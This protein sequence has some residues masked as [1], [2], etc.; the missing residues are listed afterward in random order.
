MKKSLLLLIFTL[1]F[2]SIISYSQCPFTSGVGWGGGA[3][4]ACT[5][6]DSNG[7]IG[8]TWGNCASGNQITCQTTCAGTF[9]FNGSFPQDTPQELCSA[10]LPIT[11][12]NF[13]GIFTEPINEITWTT[14]TEINN[15]YFIIYQSENGKEWNEITRLPGAGHSTE[16]KNYTIYHY[17][18]EKTINYYKLTQVDY[19]GKSETYGPISIDNRD[20]K[21]TLVKTINLMGQ[22]V[23]DSY[24]GIVIYIY[25][26]G[27]T[28]KIHR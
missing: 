2:F 25:D 26:D 24:R 10:V 19:D 11:L 13:K 28:E 1:P 15:N 17:N 20:E 3:Q 12:I 8:C 6:T 9:Y 5:W 23:Q 21:R 14:S 16:S 18:P 4:C 7:D 22:E 27:T